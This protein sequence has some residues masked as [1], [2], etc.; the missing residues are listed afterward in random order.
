MTNQEKMMNILKIL[1][2]QRLKDVHNPIHVDKISELVNMTKNETELIVN[3]LIHD[4]LA[5]DNFAPNFIKITAWGIDRVEETLEQSLSRQ[6]REERESILNYLKKVYEKDVHA[7]VGSTEISNI[8]VG[9]DPKYLYTQTDYLDEKGLVEMMRFGGGSFRVKLTESGYRYDEK[10]DLLPDFTQIVKQISSS[11]EAEVNN[12]TKPEESLDLPILKDDFADGLRV[13]ISHKFVKDDQQLALTLQEILLENHINGYLAER[14]R[15]Y[16]LPIDE[17]I[18]NEIN[19][20]DYLVAIITKKSLLSPSVHQEIGYALGIKTPVLVMVEGNLEVGVLIKARD[21]EFFD[22]LNFE[23][24]CKN[25]LS[26]VTENGKKEKQSPHHNFLRERVYPSLYDKMM[27]IHEDP[28]KF[29]TIT[30]NPWKDLEPSSKLKVEDDIKQLFEEFTTKLSDWQITISRLQQNYIINQVLLGDIIKK[31]F[32]KGS[33]IKP[34]GHIL[35]DERTSQEPRYWIEAFKFIIF[36][37]TI[38]NETI[39]YTKLLDFATQTNNGHQRWLQDWHEKIPILYSYIFESLLELRSLVKFEVHNE[40]VQKQKEQMTSIVQNI[41][42][43]LETKL[44]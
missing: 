14:K 7:W 38:T 33:L 9:K 8:L 17:K 29:K 40:Q 13:F 20:S 1:Y 44:R 28:D 37:D 3:L 22:R 36:D 15:K 19:N 42:T 10:T 23:D 26:H 18:K 35:L 27:K 12:S 2:E 34:D 41:V 31:A 5:H 30:S 43:I 32:E 4:S 11:I 6:L 21:K 39:L 25:I 24:R 16:E